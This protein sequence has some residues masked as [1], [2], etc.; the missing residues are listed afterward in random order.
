MN[1]HEF[2]S[3]L[4]VL[5]LTTCLFAYI[6]ARPA[7]SREPVAQA[8]N[9]P[10]IINIYKNANITGD[11]AKKAVEAA[12]NILNQAGYKLT[13]VKVNLNASAGDAGND[14]DLSPANNFKEFL[15]IVKA[16]KD[17]ID[18]TPNKKGIKISFV[19]TPWIN[20]TTPGWAYHNKPVVV[21][22]NRGTAKA[23]GE[24]IAHEIGH[25]LSLKP[26][27]KIDATTTADDGGHAPNTTGPTHNGN[28][29]AP[30]NRRNGTHLTPDQI[31]EIFKARYVRGKCS[32]QMEWYYPAIK[33]K[34]QYGTKTDNLNDHSGPGYGD[35]FSTTLSS[36]DGISN[37]GG[38]L[39]LGDLFS[40]TVNATYALVF[41]SD[42][43]SST[44]YSYGG[45]I[46]REYALELTVLGSGGSYSVSGLVRDLSTGSTQTL[47]EA[48]IIASVEL[49]ADWDGL[50]ATP[51]LDQLFFAL[52]KEYVGLNTTLQAMSAT[53]IL[54]GVLTK[55]SSI[56]CDSDLFVF[57]LDQWL[58]DPTLE[59]RTGVPTPGEN[60]P[61]EISGLEPNSPFDLYVDE[62]F[63]F[64][65]IL[66][67]SG[68]FSGEFVFP[69]DLPNTEM[70]FLT[71]QD[72]TGEFAYSI[73]CP[74]TTV[75]GVLV[76]FDKLALLAPYIA[77]AVA[78]VAITVGAVYVKKPWLIKAVVQTP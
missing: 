9:I 8:S 64:S 29:M 76:P 65:N 10:V 55:E 68:G 38:R 39:S 70:H 74:K 19:R 53:N 27:H 50:G 58:D 16:G 37:I 13:V 62:N 40:G 71:A 33:E 63:V 24:T 11:Q 59:T 77:L 60:Y 4:T 21:V 12:S 46:G 3:A 31:N 61:F 20:S 51:L 75:G 52:P 48:P 78:V 26:G 49:V 1:L 30:S 57:D 73:T 18:A 34:Q 17:A 22:K 45:F 32:I 66:D 44:G 28:I 15:D 23:T 6:D 72:S 43:N 7:R 14:G 36:L 25:V 5:V 67:A 41:D 69:N 47:P 35:I 2:R 54:V 56:I 42:N